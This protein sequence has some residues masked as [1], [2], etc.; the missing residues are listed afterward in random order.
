VREIKYRWQAI[1]EENQAIKTA[2]EKNEKY[3]PATLENGDTLKEL[4]ARSRYLLYK[5]P[6]DMTLNQTIRA[7]LLFKQYPVLEQAYKL[8]L[9][10]R[11]IYECPTPHVRG[12][13]HHDHLAGKSEQIGN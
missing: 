3:I 4:L 11:A 2:K 10:Y 7:S 12:Y 9:E 6:N 13:K 5:T 8:S 1:D